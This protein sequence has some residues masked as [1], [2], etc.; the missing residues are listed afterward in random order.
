MMTVLKHVAKK[1]RFHLPEEAASA[2]I[3][4]SNGNMRKALLV[5]EALRMQ[6]WVAGLG[7]CPVVSERPTDQ[8]RRVSRVP[9]PQSRPHVQH[10]DRQTRLGDVLL[11]GGRPDPTGT[12]AEAIDGRSRQ[13]VRAAVTLHSRHRRAEGECACS[14][15]KCQGPARC[16]EIPLQRQTV[17]DRL[18]EKVDDELKPQII[19]WASHYVGERRELNRRAPSNRGLFPFPP[20]RHRNSACNRA[21]RRYT[22]SRRTLQ[23]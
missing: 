23:R 4:S 19:H 10:R 11:Q 1:E 22:T 5:F 15:A 2:I 9:P 18:V 21:Q 20:G 3:D 13:G 7:R 17:T 8:P 14:S 6:R 12:V 16:P